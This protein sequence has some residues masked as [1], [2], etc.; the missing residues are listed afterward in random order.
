MIKKLRFKFIVIAMSSLLAILLTVIGAIN[1]IS[2]Y[3]TVHN[4][5]SLLIYLSQNG[6]EFGHKPGPAPGGRE[7]RGFQM[8]PETEFKTR[9][10]SVLLDANAAPT[11][12]VLDR[13][14]AISY[15]DAVAYAKKVAS[16]GKTSGFIGVYRYV[17]V[18]QA[19]GTYVGFLD[20]A[21]R[22]DAAK[23]LLL[24][25]GG[26][27]LFSLLAM[28]VLVYFF[29]ARAIRPIAASLKKQKQFITDAGHE[30][31]TPVAIISANTDVLSLTTGEN[32]WLDS[33]RNQ[34]HRLNKLVQEL[35]SLSKLGEED[36]GLSFADY[37][38]T[39]AV[40]DTA[41][42]FGSVARAQGKHLELLL[43]PDL[44]HHGDESA[45]RKLVSILLDN[46]VKYTPEGGEICVM[47]KKQNRTLVLSVQNTCE[48]IAK[49][50]LPKLFER[51]YR[52][53]SSRSRE[54]G[55]YGIGLAIAKEITEAHHGK[56]SANCPCE[57]SVVFTA[58]F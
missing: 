7:P 45:I 17:V 54:T 28:F 20:C 12:V 23:F 25:S 8:N 41:A 46:A 26:I 3:K 10:F 53:D 21:D 30:L 19:Q 51:F 43:Q 2:W 44:T 42:A 58:M 47:L 18:A 57:N 37:K 32:E 4:A 11:D 24:L 13:I 40:Y 35:L 1:G 14:A 33:I 52:V 15:D 6:G 50:E 29:S 49:E 48:P 31:K 39:E 5:D 55:G 34:T 9:C 38:I 36:Y 16:S 27:A 22:L 56:L